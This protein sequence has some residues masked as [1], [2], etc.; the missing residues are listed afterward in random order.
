MEKTVG[1]RAFPSGLSWNPN[2]TILQLYS[3][4]SLI[5][6]QHFL[7]FV[8]VANKYSSVALVAEI[9]K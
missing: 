8:N 3:H 7:Q 1:G 4:Y 5:E 6:I 9:L 2:R